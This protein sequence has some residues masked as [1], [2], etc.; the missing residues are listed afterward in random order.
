MAYI[1]LQGKEINQPQQV[2]FHDSN[3]ILNHDLLWKATL[4]FSWNKKENTFT[5]RKDRFG[6]RI[7]QTITEDELIEY[8][9]ASPLSMSHLS[10]VIGARRLNRLRDKKPHLFV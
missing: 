7:D 8:F 9:S 3:E 4:V 6:G 10:T 2:I 5:F 1:P